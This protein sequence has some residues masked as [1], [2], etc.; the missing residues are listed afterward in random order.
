MQEKVRTELK[1]GATI[2][3]TCCK[4]GLSFQELCE[5]LKRPNFIPYRKII[6]DEN[7]IYAVGQRY[8]V[9]KTV[10]GEKYTYG[11]YHNLDD[12]IKVRDELISL[13][14]RV[15]PDD[16]IGDMFIYPRN[17]GWEVQKTIKNKTIHFGFF[18]NLDDARLV[19]D[20]LC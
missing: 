3:E 12:A 7:Y 17:A 20:A 15:N 16:Y 19:R 2:E 18:Y 11:A 10:N 8:E 14:W 1:E 9:S 5:F 6:S 4:Y 13:R